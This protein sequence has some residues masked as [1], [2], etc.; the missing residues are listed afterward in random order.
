VNP[1]VSI[2]IP[3]YNDTEELKKCISCLQEQTY[4]LKKI[5]VIIVDN[6]DNPC[7]KL[8]NDS[9]FNFKV[10]D[11]KVPGSYYSRNLGFNESQGE[12]LFFTDAD[13]LPSKS[14]VQA[15]VKEIEQGAKIVGGKVEILKGSD[16]NVSL[17]EELERV[18]YF[19]QELYIKNE[20]FA[21]T[22][23]LIVGRDTF[24][25]VGPFDSSVRS[26]GDLLWG[27]TATSKGFEIQYSKEAMVRH[28]IRKS[29]GEFLRRR[30]RVV[31]GLVYIKFRNKGPEW[32][33]LE[34]KLEGG[35][36]E[37]IIEKWNI[38]LEY[39]NS[40]SAKRR[41][42]IRKTFKLL[43]YFDAIIMFMAFLNYRI[44]KKMTLVDRWRL[45]F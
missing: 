1:L 15:G 30:V 18:F 11:A 42:K 7:I 29:W 19:N 25:Q 43:N 2:I 40:L 39:Y 45:K 24:T 12:I 26:A 34:M 41:K 33:E 20:N 37:E 36:G 17:L 8:L 21:V 16:P 5:E 32:K 13:C 9:F 14:W 22:A 10:I 4:S 3:S 28:P 35:M 31:S 27:K 38:D 44:L 23:N 6:N